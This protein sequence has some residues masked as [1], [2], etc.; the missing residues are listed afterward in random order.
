MASLARRECK[1]CACLHRPSQHPVSFPP[2]L[3]SPKMASSC[4][5]LG[6]SSNE[7]NARFWMEG[8]PVPRI[9]ALPVWKI[10][11]RGNVFA[12]LGLEV[13][14]LNILTPE[15]RADRTM[16]VSDLSGRTISW[17]SWMISQLG[18]NQLSPS[19]G[20]PRRNR[21]LVTSTETL[22]DGDSEAME[23]GNGILRF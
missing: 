1:D 17:P 18:D 2:K 23:P 4:P 13:G 7:S 11:E 19:A 3:A 10:S 9:D 6:C 14:R 12:T 15:W 21:E 22:D 8:Y 5:E 16:S 20:Y